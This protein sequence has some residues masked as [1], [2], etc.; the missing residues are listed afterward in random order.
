MRLRLLA[1]ASFV[2]ALALSAC[3]ESPVSPISTSAIAD[4]KGTS[5]TTSTTSSSAT[6]IRIYATLLPPSGAPFSNAKGK[7]SW[8]SRNNNTKRELEL[9]IE[10]LPVGTAVEFFVGGVSVGTRTTDALGKAEIEFSTELGQSVPESVNGLAIEIR[11]AAGA[12]LVSGS[13]PTA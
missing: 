13:F 5:T 10:H 4:A 1:P 8:D 9:E 7:G 3:A 2:A 11:N 12:V 6:R